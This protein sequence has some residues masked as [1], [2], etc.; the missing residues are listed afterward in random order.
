[1]LLQQQLSAMQR[2]VEEE[3]D[4]LQARTAA[5]AAEAAAA[6]HREND[7]QQQVEAL[8]LQL[9][10]ERT[11]AVLAVREKEEEEQRRTDAESEVANLR[12]VAAAGAEE[13]RRMQGVCRNAEKERKA[14]QE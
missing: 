3:L 8:K 10:A 2:A 9:E 4:K 13:V 7:L 6:A 12:R 11:K 1:M 14:A 5:E